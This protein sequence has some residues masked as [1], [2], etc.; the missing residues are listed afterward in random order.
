MIKLQ[1]KLYLYGLIIITIYLFIIQIKP[2][3]PVSIEKKYVAL[4]FDDG[5]SRLTTQPILDILEKYDASA[6]FFVNGNHAQDNKELVKEI[7]ERGH[8]IGNHTIDHVWLTKMSQEEVK[9]QIYGNESLLRFLTGQEGKMLV[10]PPYGDINQTILDS[11]DL[12]FI[13][14]SVDSRDWEVQDA[15]AI[16]N[17]VFSNIQ[18][19]DIIIMHDGY[20]TT[21]QGTKEVLKR[22]KNE[23]FEVV[24]VTELFKLKNKEIPTHQKVT[25]CR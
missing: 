15:A 6:T 18:D 19:G 12:S 24:S 11:Y 14:W 9:R 2:P 7:Y 17:N 1:K 5:P 25:S 22:L 8:E 13:M 4:T 10:R 3:I 21:V 20:E 16:Q 23:G